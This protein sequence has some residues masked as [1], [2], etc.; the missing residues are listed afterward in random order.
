MREKCFKCI[1]TYLGCTKH[2]EINTSHS[3]IQKQVSYKKGD[4]K[5]YVYRL[6]QKFYDALHPSGGGNLKLILTHLCS[7]KYSEINICHLAVQNHS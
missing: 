4:K 6:T 3:H 5:Y 7:I 1:L 2:N